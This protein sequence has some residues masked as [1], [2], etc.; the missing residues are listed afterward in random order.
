MMCAALCAGG[1]LGGMLM[2]FSSSAA[3]AAGGAGIVSGDDLSAVTSYIMLAVELYAFPRLYEAVA[4][5]RDEAMY[6]GIV[7]K[8]GEHQA[9]RLVVVCGAAHA[10]GI[11]SRVRARGLHQ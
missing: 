8:A 6:Q 11:L 3:S 7:A 10:N 2:L 9:S 4:A 1:F 5:S